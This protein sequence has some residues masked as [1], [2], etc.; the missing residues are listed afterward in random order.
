MIK[1]AEF[2]NIFVTLRK[3]IVETEDDNRE[4]NYA[5]FKNSIF[6]SCL[7]FLKLNFP[8]FKSRKNKKKFE[9]YMKCI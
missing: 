1:I 2:L 3:S 7:L 4:K 6:L 9:G 5:N 8:L